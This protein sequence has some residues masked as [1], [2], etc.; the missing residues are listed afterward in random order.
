M[1]PASNTSNSSLAEQEWIEYQRSIYGIWVPVLLAIAAAAFLLNGYIVLSAKW[2]KLPTLSANLT[3]CLS[4]TAVDAW[5]SAFILI[6]LVLNSYLP[7]VHGIHLPFCLRL[8][9][10]YLR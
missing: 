5:A 10:E 3:F 8:I 1:D 4:L 2:M 7:V 9:I 6:G